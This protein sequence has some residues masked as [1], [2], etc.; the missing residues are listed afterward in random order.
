[1][2][3]PAPLRRR[4]VIVQRHAAVGRA[5]ARFLNAS[6]AQIEVFACPRRAAELLATPSTLPTDLVCGM[7]FGDGEAPGTVWAERFRKQAKIGRLVLATGRPP[8]SCPPT[9]DAI[10]EK[11]LDPY[12]LRDF[13]ASAAVLEERKLG[14]A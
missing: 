9:V 4:L 11:P 1:M 12:A 7:N 2:T 8:V 6:F 5:L 10:F 13:L 14:A 3:S